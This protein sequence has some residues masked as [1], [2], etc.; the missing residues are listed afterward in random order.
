M[1]LRVGGIFANRYQLIKKLGSGGYSEVW[2]ASDIRSKDLSIAL[3]IFASSTGLD[4][5]GLEIFENEYSL[6]FNLNHPNLLRPSHYD[7]FEDRPYL[8]MPYLSKGSCVSLCG[9]MSELNIAKFIYQMAGALDYL[10]SL[11][12]PII[13][14]DIKPDNILIDAFDN[15]IITDFG[16]SVK[17]RRTLTKSMGNHSNS[18]TT[19]YMAPERF[20][21]K[22]ADKSPVFA[23]DIFSLGV[24]VFELLTD[25]LP[26]GDQGGIVAAS[27]IE[28]TELP[29]DFSENLREIVNLCLAKNTWDRPK[30][31]EL[32]EVA[33]QY[34]KNNKWNLPV[35]EAEPEIIYS[36]S[37][38]PTIPIS[39]SEDKNRK[40]TGKIS[41]DTESTDDSENPTIL[42]NKIPS[43]NLKRIITIA[44][45]LVIGFALMFFVISYEWSNLNNAEVNKNEK[46]RNDTIAY[47]EQARL[48]SI[49]KAEEDAVIQ[50]AVEADRIDSLKRISETQSSRNNPNIYNDVDDLSHLDNK[51][52]IEQS[53]KKLVQN[54]ININQK[55]K[56]KERVI[57]KFVSKNAQ[58]V[59]WTS[60]TTF[61]ESNI[62]SYTSKVM[63]YD[64]IL[65]IDVVNIENSG[66]KISKIEVKEVKK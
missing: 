9:K 64:D 41:I 7:V 52:Y 46:A 56:I 54:S 23:N 3:K 32:K 1:F 5:M 18:G 65:K 19:A 43:R 30:A 22:L 24:T 16:I 38:T 2:L 8:V 66:N 21:K 57:K 61:S 25:E 31:S 10:H 33:F 62:D 60:N 55:Y 53:L 6:V 47:T 17:M 28:P 58:V 51:S 34:I 29:E 42:I 26:Y 45:I 36:E 48:D 15:Y 40:K 27:G 39:E 50:A 35:R 14:Q 20:S 44:S 4:N 12:P 59:I 11:N 37:D 63:S 13:H 49:A